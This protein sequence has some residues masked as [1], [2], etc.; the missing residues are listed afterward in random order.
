MVQN[1]ENK[2]YISL[3]SDLSNANGVSGFEDEVLEVIKAHTDKLGKGSRDSLLNYYL[4]DGRDP[5]LP[6]VHLDCHTDEVGFMVKA[7]RPDG[8]LEFTTIGGW[9]VSNIPAHTVRVQNADGHYVLGVIASKPPHYMTEAEKKAPLDISS[10]VID[11]GATSREEIIEDYRIRIAAPV[12]PDVTAVYDEKHD[13]IFGKAFDNRMGCASVISVMKALEGEKL[14]VRLT[15]AFASQEEVGVRGATV[16]ANHVK[17]DVAIVF[18]GCPADDTV[19]PDYQIQT[20]IGKGPMLRHIDAR[21]IT[22][23]R[24][25]RFALN[26]AYELGIPVQEAVRTGGSTNGS[27]INLSNMGVPAIVIGIP[28]RYAHTHYGISSVSDFSNGVKLAKEI[29]RRLDKDIIGSF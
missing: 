2:E 4:E 3:I 15:G 16:T 26:I 9:V 19:V 22:N 5:S 1:M 14:N 28:V 7:I 29:I 20:A 18:E 12:V 24:F 27:V 21:M 17:A 11:V 23:P 25:Q 6:L 10:L 8:M 13:R